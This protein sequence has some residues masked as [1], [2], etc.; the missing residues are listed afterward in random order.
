M[1]LPTPLQATASGMA[2]AAVF[3]V[4]ANPTS[5]PQPPAP[6]AAGSLETPGT[7]ATAEADWSSSVQVDGGILLS[8]GW[9]PREVAEQVALAGALVWL[10]RRRAYRPGLAGR[11]DA[12]LSPLPATAAAVQ[13]ALV[14]HP[15]SRPNAVPAEASVPVATATISGLPAAGV[16]LI[17]PGALAAA[18]GLLVTVLLTGQNRP[19]VP[20]VVT[21]AALSTLVGTAAEAIRHRPPHL[22]VMPTLH[23][24]VKLIE[25]SPTRHAG[26]EREKPQRR[27]NVAAVTGEPAAV[28]IVDSPSGALAQ[29]LAGLCAAGAS[30]VV[31]LG[32]WPAGASWHVDAAGH[33]HDPRRPGWAG[34][35][36]CVL[37]TVAA[38]D[39]LTVMG[40][41]DPAPPTAPDPQRSH[42]P[43]PLSPRIPR[44]ASRDT[45]AGSGGRRIQLRVL[46]EPMLSV[47]GATL[48]I[49][50]AAALQALVFLAAHPAGAHS[51]QM[52]EALWPGLPRHS[53]TGRLYTALS[54]LRG[55]IRAASGLD[56]IDNADDRYRLNPTHVDT[57][58][59]RFHTTVQHAA[60]AVTDRPLAWQ[61]V[62]DAYPA[63]VAAGRAWPWLDPIREA[64]RRHVIDAHV[65]LA[66]AAPTPRQAL[67]L[68][69][70][71]IRVDP[72][73]ADLHTRVMN[74]LA[75]LGEH[76]TAVELHDT[77]TRRLAAA[78][79]DADEADGTAVRLRGATT[80]TQ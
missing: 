58:L 7:P 23:D 71:A 28:L 68:L 27:E 37:D 67:H 44:Q 17:G 49:R 69:Q 45:R 79:L 42:R 75:A 2:G 8:G 34:P 39:L 29:R 61:A 10:R 40:H 50:R 65:V 35:R 3:S 24:A 30:N 25:S 77:Y 52:V 80:P 14:D 76:Q 62:I 59:W 57:D 26:L 16:G 33:T 36:L 41:I 22:Q 21:R 56:V 38:T 70:A 15:A 74:A 31:V 47:D 6:V 1:P 5:P 12:D 20:L 43:L 66:A 4:T 46:G 73:N 19:A 51:G 63:E 9:L 13:A 53:L 11:D 78:G 64:V 54:E 72:Y 48:T 32:Q 55:A 18:R 60:T